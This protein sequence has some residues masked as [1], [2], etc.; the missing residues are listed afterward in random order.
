MHVIET[1][2]YVID[3]VNFLHLVSLQNIYISKLTTSSPYQSYFNRI[4]YIIIPY[5]L[6]NSN[7]FLEIL[8]EV[9]EFQPRVIL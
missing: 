7:E 8:V 1:K 3:H 2:H 5:Y 6:Y 4:K 9:K